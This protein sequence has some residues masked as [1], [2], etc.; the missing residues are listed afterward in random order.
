MQIPTKTMQNKNHG[1]NLQLEFQHQ[2]VEDWVCGIGEAVHGLAEDIDNPLLYLPRGE[3]Q[4]G[5]EDTMDC[6][7]RGPVNI[8]EPKFNYV[9]QNHILAP[10]DEKWLIDNYAN[11][12][13]EIEFSDAWVA[14]GSGTTQSG[15]SLKAP[16][17]FMRKNGLIPK[18]ML[19][20]ESWMTWAD[21]HNKKRLTQVMQD[22]AHDFWLRF[23]INYEKVYAKEYDEV[24]KYDFL[25]TAGFA[26]P[27]PVNGIYPKNDNPFNHC[28][29]E[30]PKQI[31]QT[32]FDNY[33]DSCDGDFIKRLAPD[34]NLFPYSYRVIINAVNTYVQS[35]EVTT[36]QIAT[37][38]RKRKDLQLE[39]PQPDMVSI[40]NPN[41][42]IFDWA[43]ERGV[44]ENPEVFNSDIHFTPIA[45]VDPFY[46]KFWKVVKKFG[47]WLSSK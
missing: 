40:H 33:P 5:R 43:R 42:S 41:Y 31:K 4:R 12:E 8:L 20:L 21:Y 30:I 19:P 16:L 10:E 36:E 14:I 38:W 44:N 24:R 18:K 47:G 1:L 45:E 11:E 26:W 28:W 37:V 34:Y 15:N 17:D 13:G 9:V 23:T 25:D 22:I 39:F 46:I 7:T 3:I 29:V 35:H 2:S 27:T 6:A 32:I